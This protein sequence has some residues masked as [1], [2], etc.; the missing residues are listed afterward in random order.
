MKTRLVNLRSE[1]L[2]AEEEKDKFNKQLILRRLLNELA[3]LLSQSM[4]FNQIAK[5]FFESGIIDTP[6]RPYGVYPGSKSQYS[7]EKLMSAQ[8]EVEFPEMLHK[9]YFDLCWDQEGPEISGNSILPLME[10][11]GY[12]AKE[13][14][15]GWDPFLKVPN[16]LPSLNI[17]N[18]TQ[19]RIKTDNLPSSL[20]QLLNEL[21]DNLERKKF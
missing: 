1:Q 10:A 14:K 19:G 4:T 8:N 9:I 3:S 6:E 17:T 15:E 11:L 20:T 5:I 16:R 7:L 2:S 21:N 18:K 13:E 12:E